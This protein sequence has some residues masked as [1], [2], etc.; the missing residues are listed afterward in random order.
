MIKI[1]KK[2]VNCDKE[3]KGDYQGYLSCGSMMCELT[4]QSFLSYESEAGD[5]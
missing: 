5:R 3:A 1:N 2:C 4:I